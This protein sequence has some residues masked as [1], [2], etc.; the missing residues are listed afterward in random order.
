M[1]QA[2]LDSI[3]RFAEASDAVI[4]LILIGSRARAAMPADAYSDTDLVLVVNDAAPFL[5]EDAWLNAIGTFHISFTEPTVDG[6]QERRVLFDG[7]QDVDF[8][9][10]N[11]AAAAQALQTGDAAH[12]LRRGYR[13]LVDKC[14]FE[15]PPP[16]PATPFRPATEAVFQNTVQ[17]FWY[18]AVW[19]AKKLLRQETWTAKFCADSYMKTKL[20]WMIE[21]HEHIVRRSGQDTWYAGRFIERWANGD[22]L[23][24]LRDTFARYDR[25]DIA[26]ALIRTMALFRRL[27]VEVADA[28]GYSYPKHADDYAARWVAERLAPLLQAAPKGR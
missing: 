3:I 1:Q 16:V 17:D 14:G 28:T 7:A 13:V 22:I 11:E 6:Q 15:L 25:A 12:I 20:L 27:A 19:T 9:I 8:V 2:L 10:I 21:Q 26:A 18:H 4:A 5:R 23:F 24:S